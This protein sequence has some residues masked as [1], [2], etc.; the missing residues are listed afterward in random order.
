MVY[1][2]WLRVHTYD[3]QFFLFYLI[4][5]SNI[6][7]KILL[8]F[9]ESTWIR[10]I[11]YFQRHVCTKQARQLTPLSISYGPRSYPRL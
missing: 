7:Y 3:A 2:Y 10:I 8:F 6:I 4:G 11:N 5:V 1:Y 9:T